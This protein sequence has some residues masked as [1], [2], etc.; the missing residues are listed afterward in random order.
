M[1]LSPY[2]KLVLKTR[3]HPEYIHTD[4]HF[5]ADEPVFLLA[6]VVA[7]EQLFLGAEWPRVRVRVCRVTFR[8]RRFLKVRHLDSGKRGSNLDAV[9][10]SFGRRHETR[11]LAKN[12]ISRCPARKP[13]CQR[14]LKRFELAI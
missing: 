12:F 4:H 8:P 9:E 1:R 5:L 7:P 11:F 2:A 6:I 14:C 13:I 3:I 10:S